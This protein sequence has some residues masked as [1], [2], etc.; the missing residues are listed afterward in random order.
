MSLYWRLMR[1]A[2]MML[3]PQLQLGQVTESDVIAKLKSIGLSDEFAHIEY[4]R[5]SFMWPGQAT[6][7]YFGL[8]KILQAKD[9]VQKAVGARFKERAFHD[10]LLDF[11]TVPVDWI[12][13]DVI[14]SLRNTPSQLPTDPAPTRSL[15]ARAKTSA[16][17]TKVADALAS[18]THI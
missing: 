7:Y 10:A 6:S 8:L 4:Q 18:K 13:E 9:D 2:R 11:G 3:D 17:D 5:Y 16:A 1:C 15:D 12:V 14:A